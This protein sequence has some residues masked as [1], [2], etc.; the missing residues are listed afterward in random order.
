MNNDAGKF[1][2]HKN[3]WPNVYPPPPLKHLMKVVLTCIPFQCKFLRA[4]T[5]KGSL[6]LFCHT[7][8]VQISQSSRDKAADMP[9]TVIM[10]DFNLYN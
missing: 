10:G 4:L 9:Q 3:V 8:L 6:E 5:H 1:R 2:V 7:Y